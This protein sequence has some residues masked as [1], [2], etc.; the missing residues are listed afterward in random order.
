LE[1]EIARLETLQNDYETEL[2]QPDIHMRPD[3]I[4]NLTLEIKTIRRQLEDYYDQWAELLERIEAETK[5][6][7]S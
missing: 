3:R 4:R 2:C 6:G 1:A 7:A 5:N